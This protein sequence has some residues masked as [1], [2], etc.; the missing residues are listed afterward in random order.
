MNNEAVGRINTNLQEAIESNSSSSED[1]SMPGLQ[2]R[3]R[4]DSS[5]DE[6]TDSC[7]ENEIYDNGEPWGYKPLILNQISGGKPGGMFHR[8]IPTL[9]AF[10]LHVYA[11]VCKNPSIE[12]TSDFY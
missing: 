12:A 11:Q 2:D 5:S 9:Y 4:E 8:N 6:D 1:G 3:A 10:R 7:N